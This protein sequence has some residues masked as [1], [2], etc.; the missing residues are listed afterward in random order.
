MSPPTNNTWPQTGCSIVHSW[1]PLRFPLIILI[2]RITARGIYSMLMPNYLV[3]SSLIG[4]FKIWTLYHEP[5]SDWSIYLIVIWLY[6]HRW[7]EINVRGKRRGNHEWT[8]QRNWQHY[9]YKTENEGA[10]RF[11]IWTLTWPHTTGR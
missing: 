5:L 4:R 1:L 2:N 11:K 9:V 3:G 7:N 10:I 8:I 6:G